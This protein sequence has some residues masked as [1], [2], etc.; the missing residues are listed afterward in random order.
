MSSNEMRETISRVRHT[1]NLVEVHGEEN[2]NRLLG[3]IQA[4]DEVLAAWL[5]TEA[6]DAAD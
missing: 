3:S 4:L 5:E 2:L 1:L 6:K